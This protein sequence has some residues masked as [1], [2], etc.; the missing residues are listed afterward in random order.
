MI[1]LFLVEDEK[2]SREGIRNIAWKE[3][4]ILY[5]GDAP[6][7]DIA[8][9]QILEKKPDILLTDIKMP[10]INGLQLSQLVKEKLPDIKIILLS[11]YNEF[12]YAKQAISIGINEYLLKPVSSTDILN[13]VNKVKKEI[14]TLRQKKR[15]EEYGLTIQ[16]Q[17]FLNALFSG[18]LLDTSDIIRYAEKINIHLYSQLYQV[19]ILHI[20]ADSGFLMLDKYRTFL[21]PPIAVLAFIYNN[22]EIIYL[23]Q[24]DNSDQLTA[25]CSDLENWIKNQAT[26]QN[27]RVNFQRGT[28][29]R[30]ISDITKS[31]NSAKTSFISENKEQLTSS[32][33]S[34]PFKR[35][36]LLEFLR[37]GK[38]STI[39]CFWE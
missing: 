20:A 31:Y 35:E 10:F 28:I 6:D 23:L 3:N 15:E 22:S 26:I 1:S 27:L 21:M 19:L 11:G 25:M 39:E 33:T 18:Y 32:L 5:L 2:I 30:R 12:D 8:L 37:T 36:D 34:I 16:H 38:I 17:L 4:G 14:E 24:S 29:V 13:S 7:G 9:P